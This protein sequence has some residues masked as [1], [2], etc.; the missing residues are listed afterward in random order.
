MTRQISAKISDVAEQVF[1]YVSVVLPLFIL[2]FMP[3]VRSPVYYSLAFILIS[4]FVALSLVLFRRPMGSSLF[5]LIF[6]YVLVFGLAFLG[7]WIEKLHTDKVL[8]SVMIYL[9]ISSFVSLILFAFLQIEFRSAEER[10]REVLPGRKD[11]WQGEAKVGTGSEISYIRNNL[12]VISDEV[13][14]NIEP[15]IRKVQELAEIRKKELEREHSRCMALLASLSEIHE[16]YLSFRGKLA[17]SL[18]YIRKILGVLTKHSGSL[19]LIS[20]PVE[21]IGSF[22]FS[23]SYLSAHGEQVSALRNKMKEA[24]SAIDAV[25]SAVTGGGFSGGLSIQSV[26]FPIKPAILEFLRIHYNSYVVSLKTVQLSSASGSSL[27]RKLLLAIIQDIDSLSFK[28]NVQL[29]AIL[30]AFSDFEP[31][32]Y[33][34]ERRLKE[35]PK[36]LAWMRN[37]VRRIKGM[38]QNSSRKIPA[39]EEKLSEVANILAISGFSQEVENIR[40]K[41]EEYVT[42]L[43]EVRKNISY[44]LSGFLEVEAEFRGIIQ[45]IDNVV[46]I[47]E[48]QRENL[49]EVLSELEEMRGRIPR[50]SQKFLTSRRMIDELK[51]IAS[52]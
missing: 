38:C 48:S 51:D 16:M 31:Y 49:N 33:M 45:E 30:Q 47:I 32:A 7:F 26:L 34:F 25:Y 52:F 3:K 46:G 29:S 39:F 20:V 19:E 18:E 13:K 28:L 15:K 22:T 43:E 2:M 8:L 35:R 6:N 12:A 11:V 40:R 1:R 42:K 4:S 24:E 21:K 44:L 5:A 23:Q 9:V 41:V 37:H 50:L 36:L 27:V 10:E 14:E 17:Y